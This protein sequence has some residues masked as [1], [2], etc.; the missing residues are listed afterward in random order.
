MRFWKIKR[1]DWQR[2]FPILG[3]H[4]FIFGFL[5]IFL[6]V[7][8]IGIACRVNLKENQLI[9]KARQIHQRILTV[10]CHCDTPMMMLRPGWDIGQRHEPGQKESGKIDLPRMREGGLDALFFSVFVGQGPL[11]DEGYAKARERASQLI[12]VVHKMVKDYS[13]LIGLALTPQDAYQLKKEGKLIAFLGLENGYPIGRDLSRLEEYYR[14]G[15]RYLTLC[16]SQDNDICDSATDRLNPEDKGL[17]EFGRQVI[18]AC[19]RLGIMV[20]VSHISDQSFWD[21]IQVS[22][23]PV[24]ASHSSC[25]ALCPNPRNLSDEMIKALAKKGGVIQICF[26]SSY[27]RQPKPNPE[28]D[29]AIKD[30]EAKYGG[31]IR[32]IQDEVLRQKAL[33]ELNEIRRRFPQEIATVKDVA[34][35]IEHVIKIAG[36]DYVGIGT[37]FDGGGGVEGC[38]DVSEMFNVTVE[39]LRRGYK[40]KDLAKIWGGNLM[41]VFNE[42]IKVAQ[43]L[44]KEAAFR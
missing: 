3:R 4:D 34:D 16:H 44:Q 11:T 33:E 37:D 8:S 21:V 27:L 24:I 1:S 18:K 32:A 15:I 38:N 13:N 30:L 40:E 28:R 17:S 7:N 39:L 31:N 36:I 5:V 42:V 23:A 25:R 20:D 10:D 43:C 6:F 35:H 22:E 26:L 29:K 9:A 41:R 2:V 19:N 14:L 12:Q